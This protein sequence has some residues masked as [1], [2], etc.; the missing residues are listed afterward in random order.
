M[1]LIHP[2]RKRAA[3]SVRRVRS[4]I[5]AVVV[6]HQARLRARRPQRLPVLGVELGDAGTRRDPGQQHT[7][8]QAQLGDLCYL[9]DGLV[10]VP[11]QNLAH[12]G[13]PLGRHSAEVGQPAIVRT[14]AGPAQL[15][16][17]T[18]LRLGG[19]QTRLRKERWHGIGEEDLPRDAFPIQLRVSPTAVPV[20]LGVGLGEVAERVDVCLCPAVEFVPVL[21]IEVLAIV[22][23]VSA[24][25]AVSR[26]DRVPVHALYP[27]RLGAGGESR[28]AS[29]GG[30]RSA[31]ARTAAAIPAAPASRSARSGWCA[32]DTT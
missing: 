7:A 14:Q 16:L 28:A 23:Q 27:R 1:C 18:G 10:E 26:N 8:A 21:R 17:P 31:G 12:P 20:A 11:E 30:R 24:G 25:V 19:S 4:G 3:P 5:A 6:D 13:A 2:Y 32:G 15:E 9:G 22:E 29:S